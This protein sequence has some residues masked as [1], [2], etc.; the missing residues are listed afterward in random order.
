MNTDSPEIAGNTIEDNDA[1]RGQR[2]GEFTPLTA[3]I[4]IQGTQNL[5][6]E[7]NIIRNNIGGVGI[8]ILLQYHLA[9]KLVIAQNLLYGNRSDYAQTGTIVS[10]V[11][12]FGSNPRPTL[13]ETNNTIYGGETLVWTFGPSIIENNIFANP[14]PPPGSSS[15]NGGLMCIDQESANSPLTI[16]NN[17]SYI[18]GQTPHYPCNMGS[19]NLYTDPNFRDAANGDFH[20]QDTSPTIAT[21]DINAPNIPTA[22]LDNKAR[23]VCNTIDMGVYELRPHPPVTIL[24]SANP[25]PGGSTIIF[26]AQVIGNCNVPTGTVTFYDGSTAIGTASLNSSAAATLATALLVV[27]QH[28][29]TAQYSGDF[30]FESNTSDALIQTITGDP[31][32]TSLT[33]SPNPATAL[34]PI[35]LSSQVTSPYGTPTGSVTF[36]AEGNVIATAPLNASGQATGTTTTLSAGSYQIVANY[37]AD[38]RF[39]PSSSLAV[40]ETVVGADSITTLAATP[41]PSALT[42]TVTFTATVR[43]TQGTVVPT[44]QVIFS[45]GANS[46]GTVSVP[47]NGIA[48]LSSSSLSFGRHTITAHYGGSNYFNP[49]NAV[50]SQSVTLIGTTLTLTATPNPANMGQTVTL[51]AASTSALAGMTPVGTVTFYDGITSLGT[52]DLASNGIAVFSTSSLSVGSHTLQATLSSSAYFTA[53][54]R[55][56]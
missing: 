23:I 33:V 56:A 31:T 36:T 46:I 15:Y 17:D 54:H 13:I 55:L 52:A 20:T 32:T 38:T 45:D 27:G 47:A 37:T 39:Q 48:S 53:A 50:V 3:G 9:Q 19:S 16:Q 22:D 30:N 18:A 1:M 26:T 7:N 51:T 49:S 40:Q 2:P 35:T 12:I 5:L 8:H 24:S 11:Y 43:A 4:F 21:G 29:I 14:A 6:L 41:S 42:Q 10:Q 28:R 34:S 25:T 44:G